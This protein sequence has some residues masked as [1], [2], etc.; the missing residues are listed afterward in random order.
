MPPS[1]LT[2][3]PT[4]FP[5]LHH[6]GAGLTPGEAYAYEVGDPSVPSGTSPRRSFRA[7]TLALPLPPPSPSGGGGA[8][9]GRDGAG[10]PG[11]ATGGA[12]RAG[13][14]VGLRLAV[15]ADMGV[16]PLYAHALAQV[17]QVRHVGRVGRA[18][19]QQVPGT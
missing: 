11:A 9:E 14:E 2:N 7:P 18:P 10:V 15:V 17:A 6:H 8:D 5:H 4:F 3:P 16:T 13:A 1:G 19:R 12:G